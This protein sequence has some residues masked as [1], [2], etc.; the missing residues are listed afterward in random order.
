LSY[1]RSSR[2]LNIVLNTNKVCHCNCVILRIKEN[3]K[4]TLNVNNYIV[5]TEITH[6]R[7]GRCLGRSMPSHWLRVDMNALYQN[8]RPTTPFSSY[9][10]WNLKPAPPSPLSV[11]LLCLFR[12]SVFTDL[13]ARMQHQG[14][15]VSAV[16]DIA[17]HVRPT[18]R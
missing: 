15:R 18:L 13:N 7:R 9:H 11:F 12:P 5:I 1:L 16:W 10:H 14:T 2:R 3:T 8:P 4:S 6:A 17:S